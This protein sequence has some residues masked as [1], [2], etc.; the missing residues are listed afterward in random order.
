MVVHAPQPLRSFGNY[1]VLVDAL[2]QVGS[3]CVEGWSKN[4]VKSSLEASASD[5]SSA[6][7][8][9]AKAHKTLLHW[10]TGDELPAYGQNDKGGFCAL[11]LTR[12]STPYFD[13]DVSKSLF[14][15]APDE[16]GAIFIGRKELRAQIASTRGGRPR[17]TTFRWQDATMIAWQIALDAPPP[18]KRAMLIA[19]IQLRCQGD[20]DCEP[21]EKELGPIVDAIIAHL[22]DRVLSKEV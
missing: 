6:R 16:W 20:L 19:D 1:L 10:L 2:E 5:S 14:K 18:R 3:K 7:E 15:W 22:D 4:D 21:G 8:R 17:K 11:E 12:L 9:Y 13:I